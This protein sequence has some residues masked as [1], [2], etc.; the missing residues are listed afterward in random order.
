M[1]SL[2]KALSIQGARL[3]NTYA[4]AIAKLRKLISARHRDTKP[5]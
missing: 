5:N 3:P 1:T 4:A 2:A